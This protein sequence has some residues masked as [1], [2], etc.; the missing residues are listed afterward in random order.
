MPGCRFPW[1]LHSRTFRPWPW[2]GS[3]SPVVPD[4]DRGLRTIEDKIHIGGLQS[5]RVK[6][7]EHRQG[8]GSLCRQ[9]LHQHGGLQGIVVVMVLPQRTDQLSLI[10]DRRGLPLLMISLISPEAPH[11]PVFSAGNRIPGMARDLIPDLR[12][13]TRVDPDRLKSSAIF[14]SAVELILRHD[15]AERPIP[16][17]I[18]KRMFIPR[19]GDV[20]QLIRV[21]VADKNR[22]RGITDRILVTSQMIVDW[23]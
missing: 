13:E 2:R 10:I 4:P 7:M 11:H 19:L 18:L 16:F 22:M 12:D 9:I 20:I 15:F 3:P 5:G 6:K 1:H 21:P 23:D 17:P 8:S 14:I